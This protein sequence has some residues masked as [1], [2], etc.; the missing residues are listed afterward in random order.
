MGRRPRIV[1]RPGVV[2]GLIIALA[3]VCAVLSADFNAPPRFDG[4]GY[5]V[6]ARALATGEGYREIDR[7]NSPRHAH[8]PPGY[9]IALAA[10]WRITGW[11]VLAA[12]ALSLILSV[13]ATLAAWRWFRAIEGS[14][15]AMLLGLALAV[16]WTWARSA[17]AIQ[18]EPLYLLLSQLA[19]LVATR[20]A[21]CGGFAQGIGLGILL[22]GSMLTR[23]VGVAV[24]AAV[25]VDLFQRR[26]YLVALATGLSALLLVLPWVAWLA[27]VQKPTQVELLARGGVVERLAA[28]AWFYLERI[29]D[30]LTGPVVEVGSSLHGSAVIP[31]AVNTWAVIATALILF[32]WAR[33]VRNSRRRLAAL[34]GAFTLAL[35]LVWPFTEAGRF[36]I[37]LVPCLLVGAVEGLAPLLVRVAWVQRPKTAAAGIV[38]AISL[39]Y[40]AYALAAGRPHA[41]QHTHDDFDAACAWIAHQ[42]DNPGPVLSSHPGEVYWQTGRTGLPPGPEPT[43]T[44]IERLIDEYHISYLL[45]SEARYANAPAG[46]LSAYAAQQPRR[47]REVWRRGSTRV[48]EVTKLGPQR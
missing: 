27:L 4:A 16:N 37:P 5:A 45:T 44:K 21:R 3:T 30:Q 39:P 36:L 12:H 6:L 9:P 43:P 24:A 8:F 14:R 47:V 18:S 33:S 1:D 10:L 17:A 15:V 19:V 40:S 38:L 41:Q 13:A 29:P 32:G 35:L 48:Y 46:P 26:R 42:T 25:G 22:G 7:P 34:V 2:A 11:S 20:A 28:Q 23:Q 31:T